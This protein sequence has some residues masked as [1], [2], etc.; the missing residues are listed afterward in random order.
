MDITKEE[1]EK[2]VKTLC[3]AID[4]MKVV[5]YK[6][7]DFIKSVANLELWLE[8]DFPAIFEMLLEEV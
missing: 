7:Q 4:I 8:K 1:A 2:S 6:D 5:R 3:R